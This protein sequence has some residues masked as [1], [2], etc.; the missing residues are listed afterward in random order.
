MPFQSIDLIANIM[1]G[2][3]IN[4]FKGEK[5]LKPEKCPCLRIPDKWLLTYIIFPSMWF[6]ENRWVRCRKM[7]IYCVK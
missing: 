4:I 7:D 6:V 1:Y 2:I 3:C 5:N